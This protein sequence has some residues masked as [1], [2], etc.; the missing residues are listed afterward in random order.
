M[1]LSLD[2]THPLHRQASAARGYTGAA[3]QS[4]YDAWQV[5]AD[6]GVIEVKQ[7]TMPVTPAKVALVNEYGVNFTA[8]VRA[9]LLNQPQH[10]VRGLQRA[11]CKA[12]NWSSLIGMRRASLVSQFLFELLSY[13]V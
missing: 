1:G 7:G 9:N 6:L 11:T 13:A 5:I 12:L 8:V 2:R 4:E 10:S 3:L